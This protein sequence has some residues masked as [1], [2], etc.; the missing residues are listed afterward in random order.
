MRRSIACLVGVIV[1]LFCC[2]P[3]LATF[4]GHPGRIAFFDLFGR[5][6]SEIYSVAPD[7]SARRQLTPDRHASSVD[8]AWSPSGDTIAY[9][10]QRNGCAQ[11]IFAM[12]ADGT[13]RRVLFDPPATPAFTTVEHPTWSPDGTEIAFCATT[14]HFALRIWTVSAD[15]SSATL[16]NIS[17]SH[18]GDCEPDWSPDGSKIA[19]A[20][21]VNGTV[22]TMNV[23]GTGRAVVAGRGAFNP[24]WSPDSSRI[25]FARRHRGPTDLFS[26][27]ADGSDV[28]ALTDTPNRWEWQAVYSPNGRRI[29]FNR[30]QSRRRASPD[31]LWKMRADGSGTHPLTRTLNVDEWGPEW[32]AT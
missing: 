5:H 7:G 16:T 25:L 4:P 30:S 21:Y 22:E 6:G 28:R 32:Q 10:G 15:G 24:S 27:A 31:D 23:D 18:R 20:D 9:T 29:V 8:P 14:P 2:S 13:N 12:N 17:G 19:F 3:A 11:C 26:A 1:S